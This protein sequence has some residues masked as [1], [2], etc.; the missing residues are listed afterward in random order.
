MC[1]GAFPAVGG[2]PGVRQ[3]SIAALWRPTGARG[4]RG[5][6]GAVC[7]IAAVQRRA[8]VREGLAQLQSLDEKRRDG[9][10]FG[11]RLEAILPLSRINACPQPAPAPGDCTQPWGQ[12]VHLHA[13]VD[14]LGVVPLGC[15]FM[16]CSGARVLPRST[17]GAF[18]SGYFRN[19]DL[20]CGFGEH[21][22]KVWPNARQAACLTGRQGYLTNAFSTW[23]AYCHL[24]TADCSGA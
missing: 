10:S 21:S 12:Q 16:H 11:L 14:G 20:A 8:D 9:A 4:A 7:R 24:E 6:A 23:P 17:F 18:V 22:V 2:L 15:T 5:N 1:S 19:P 3:A 13:A